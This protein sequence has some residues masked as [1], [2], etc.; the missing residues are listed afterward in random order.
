MLLTARLFQHPMPR[1]ARSQN[2]FASQR[3]QVSL[4]C[5]RHRR[6]GSDFC[7]YHQDRPNFCEALKEFF[8]ECTGGRVTEEA[9]NS[10]EKRRFPKA[11]LEFGPIYNFDHWISKKAAMCGVE[12]H[13]GQVC[14]KGQGGEG[15][16]T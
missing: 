6:D 16:A 8:R 9:F 2:A 15:A 7:E 14:S 3:N 1:H 11:A 5:W 12:I 13:D 10:W 4:R